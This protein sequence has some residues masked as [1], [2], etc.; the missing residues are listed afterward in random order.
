[1]IE[2]Q[3]TESE[4]MKALE[5]CIIQD[6]T[7]KE[8][9]LTIEV[10]DGKWCDA[11]LMELTLD[12]INHKNAEIEQWKAE[13]KRACAERDAHICTTKFAKAE[14]IKEV[15]DELEVRLAVLAF[16]SASED[17]TDGMFDCMEWVDGKIDELKEEMG[18][19]E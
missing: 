10:L 18:C 12:L 14:A 2:K 19:G 4:I 15:L 9:P 13:Y 17:Y 1:M 8:C 6:D 3:M 16:K 5:C 7:C 11:R